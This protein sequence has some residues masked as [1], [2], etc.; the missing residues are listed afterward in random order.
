MEIAVHG[1]IDHL[2]T[3]EDTVVPHADALARHLAVDRVDPVEPFW[4]LVDVDQGL[5]HGLGR[6]IDHELEIVVSLLDDEPW[7][8]RGRCDLPP[9]A[10]ERRELVLDRADRVVGVTRLRPL[11]SRLLS[12]LAVGVTNLRG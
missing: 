10:A 8:R 1:R 11:E 7:R 6:R 5:A 3:V 9:V 12:Y 2:Q 4:P